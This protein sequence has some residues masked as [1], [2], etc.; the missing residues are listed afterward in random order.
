MPMHRRRI[1]ART[2]K[3]DAVRLFA[4]VV[5]YCTAYQTWPIK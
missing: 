1:Y 3:G 2:H 5:M 4:A